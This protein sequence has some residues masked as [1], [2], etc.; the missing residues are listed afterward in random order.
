MIKKPF[1]LVGAE[2]SGT[3]LL[4]LM[5]DHNPRVACFQEF[6]CSVDF[7][8][9][10]GVFPEVGWMRDLLSGPMFRD[11]F[12]QGVPEGSDTYPELMDGILAE[13]RDQGGKELIGATVHRHFDRLI[14]IWPDAV[15]IHLVRDGR[16]VARS[17][18]AMGWDGNV[19]TAIDEWVETAG[20][21]D[22]LK[23]KVGVSRCHEV[24]YEELI[25][26]PQAELERICG[27]LGTVYASEMM[28]YSENSTYSVPDPSLVYQ[29]RKKALPS[30]IQLMEHKALETL[31][32]RGYEASGLDRISVSGVEAK[33]LERESAWGKRR[34]RL[35]RYGLPLVAMDILSR[36]LPLP[37][38]RRWVEERLAIVRRRHLK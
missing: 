12:P 27:F 8:G 16:D 5:L 14:H 18:I 33:K 28:S 29:W 25:A 13:K 31:L 6:E 30:E 9:D 3:T 38:F 11:M 36:R 17:R 21:W 34:F 26:E 1:F 7:V 23:A 15:F 20:L 37:S 4:R 32:Q 35:R 2:R 24:R 19:W 10:D 22:G